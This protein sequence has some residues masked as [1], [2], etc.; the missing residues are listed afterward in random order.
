MCIRDRNIT[1][2]G[3]PE[4]RPGEWEPILLP[5]DEVG[6]SEAGDGSPRGCSTHSP[7]GSAH[8]IS[9]AHSLATGGP[10]QAL[11]GPAS[12]ATD[13]ESHDHGHRQALHRDS[14]AG[15]LGLDQPTLHRDEGTLASAKPL[16]ALATDLGPD[17]TSDSA[18]DTSSATPGQTAWGPL[19]QPD[20]APLRPL[21]NP[22]SACYMNSLVTGLAWSA[23][24]AGGLSEDHW[25]N[26]PRVFETIADVS[27]EGCLLYTSP[28]PRDA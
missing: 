13:S 15:H 20:Q 6:S 8:P 25:S 9:D 7:A 5:K 11:W 18:Q 24:W 14:M 2:P 4:D 12:G 21:T 17:A 10:D 1:T 19:I 22:A 26:F 28:S 23:R 3:I 16:W 27:P